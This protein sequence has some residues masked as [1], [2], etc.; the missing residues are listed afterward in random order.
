MSFIHPKKQQ[1][2]DETTNLPPK[3]DT[4]TPRELKTISK[5]SLALISEDEK[6]QTS[7]RPGTPLTKSLSRRKSES[8][9]ER[10]KSWF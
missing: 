2:E 8:T 6:S 7:S 10:G 5:R 1:V 4:T 3:Q 9:K